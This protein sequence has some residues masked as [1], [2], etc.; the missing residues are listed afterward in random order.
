[1]QRLFRRKKSLTGLYVQSTFR[2]NFL[3]RNKICARTDMRNSTLAP[4]NFESD[5][6]AEV[7]SMWKITFWT[8]RAGYVQGEFSTL[9]QDMRPIW[10]KFRDR[11]SFWLEANIVQV[12]RCTSYAEVLKLYGVTPPRPK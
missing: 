7:V 12:L 3:R 2:E 11:L 1:M 4:Q 8:V 10:P 6:D 5:W 9:E